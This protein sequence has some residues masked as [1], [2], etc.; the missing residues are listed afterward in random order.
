MKIEASR[1][2]VSTAL[3]RQPSRMLSGNVYQ[4]LATSP[5]LRSRRSLRSLAR[6]A[7][8][9]NITI[10]AKTFSFSSVFLYNFFLQGI[11]GPFKIQSKIRKK[12]IQN[13]IKNRSKMDQKSIQNRSQ[14]GLK[15]VPKASQT[16]FEKC[17][18]FG[19]VKK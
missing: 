4:H 7:R 17:M 8:R 2:H 1:E 12:N 9:T 19:R 16:V 14:D 15:R 6:Y 3:P 13:S 11:K 18:L 5:A 10:R